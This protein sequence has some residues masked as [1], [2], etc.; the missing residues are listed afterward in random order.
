IP[1]LKMACYAVSL[2]IAEA[3]H[4]LMATYALALIILFLAWSLPNRMW[5]A[6]SLG[7]LTLFALAAAICIYS[8]S[9]PQSEEYI[10]A[11]QTRA[12]W[13]IDTW[14]WYEV[15]GVIGPLLVIAAIARFSKKAGSDENR[16]IAQTA[17]SAGALGITIASLFAHLSSASYAVARLQPL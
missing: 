1:R 12:Y 2:L 8:L 13:F 11:A 15:F 16:L 14:Q 5:R 9:P 3:A 6:I 17:V 10:R 7:G 4:P